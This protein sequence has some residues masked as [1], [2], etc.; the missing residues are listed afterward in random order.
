MK[1]SG[2]RNRIWALVA[3]LGLTGCYSGQDP[4]NLTVIAVK[5]VLAGP[6]PLGTVMAAL[7]EEVSLRGFTV[8]FEAGRQGDLLL[9]APTRSIDEAIDQFGVARKN[10]HQALRRSLKSQAEL[11]KLDELEAIS[12]SGEIIM[13]S[14]IFA[15]GPRGEIRAFAASME[16]VLNE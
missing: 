4:E 16:G 14:T 2:V 11:A 15:D 7:P 1:Y 5:V 9:T 8:Q 6:R 13:V 3:S 10:L 12:P